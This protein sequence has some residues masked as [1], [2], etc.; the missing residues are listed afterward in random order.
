MPI[1]LRNQNKEPRVAVS[2]VANT[3][4]KL[5]TDYP[6]G[7]ATVQLAPSDS[8]NS[9]YMSDMHI[10]DTLTQFKE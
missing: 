3:V 4:S 2:S 6:R 1:I 9:S 10:S 8:K 7:Y 5:P